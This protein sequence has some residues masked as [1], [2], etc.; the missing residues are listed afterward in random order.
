[1]A[2]RSR[3]SY[4][5]SYA[6]VWG[7][8]GRGEKVIVTVVVTIKMVSSSQPRINYDHHDNIITIT[9]SIDLCRSITAIAACDRRDA[10]P[11][12]IFGRS[13]LSTCKR[14][15]PWVETLPPTI[16]VTFYRHSLCHSAPPFL[17]LPTATHSNSICP[18][19]DSFYCH[20]VYHALLLLT[21]SLL[22]PVC[23]IT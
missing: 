23:W 16:L 12:I 9:S 22:P 7:R 19:S 13:R 6:Y 4:V 10:I 18:H 17:S 11:C 5:R 8:A 20:L 3:T 2:S 14:Q 15:M 1:M 21:P